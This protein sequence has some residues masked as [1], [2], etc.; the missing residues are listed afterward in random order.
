M[1]GGDDLFDTFGVH[2]NAGAFGFVR[3][4]GWPQGGDA[5]IAKIVFPLLT[6]ALPPSALQHDHIPAC[7]RQFLRHN[8]APR[9]RADDHGV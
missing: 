7:F 1:G 2:K 5:L 3:A 6:R 8:S 4:V 9:S